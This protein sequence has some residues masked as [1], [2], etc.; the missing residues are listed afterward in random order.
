MQLC[1]QYSIRCQNHILTIK[2]YFRSLHERILTGHVIFCCMKRSLYKCSLPLRHIGHTRTNNGVFK[3]VEALLQTHS[4]F[5]SQSTNLMYVSYRYED[6]TVSLHYLPRCVR[7]TVSCNKT[8]AT[9]ILSE[10]LQ[11]CCCGIVTQ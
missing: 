4:C 9:V 11:V 6:V 1:T 5:F 10:A 8:P 7:S 3:L 2:T